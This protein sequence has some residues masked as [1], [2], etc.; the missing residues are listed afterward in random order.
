MCSLEI[1]AGE[2][3]LR[4]PGALTMTGAWGEMMRL[5]MERLLIVGVGEG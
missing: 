3:L 1:H 2:G 4:R 5:R